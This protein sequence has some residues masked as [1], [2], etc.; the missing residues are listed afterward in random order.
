MNK[1]ADKEELIMVLDDDGNPTGKLEKRSIVHDKELLHNEIALW[2]IDPETNQ[3]L[4]QRRSPNKRI[5]PNKLG[6][7]AGHVVENESIEQT[8][9]TE[10]KEEIGID[11]ND[12]DVKKFL[13]MKRIAP[14]NHHITHYFYIK[15]YIPIENFKIQE[16]ELSEVIYFDYEKLKGMAKSDENESVFEFE[17]SKKMFEALDKIIYNKI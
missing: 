10:A 15:K 14:N 11:I 2:I 12:F 16:E 17:D 5:D 8:L 1:V 3:V 4:L 13:V 7:C 6:I 9:K